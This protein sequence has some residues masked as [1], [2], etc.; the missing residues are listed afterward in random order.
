MQL[1][2]ETHG[3]VRCLYG[4]AIDLTQLGTVEITR[5]SHVEP[6]T[7]GQWLVDLPSWRFL[8]PGEQQS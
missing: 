2:V 7:K 8:Y 4:E 5:G 1:I 3:S 6:G